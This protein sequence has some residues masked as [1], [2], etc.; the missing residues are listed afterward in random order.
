MSLQLAVGRLAKLV[1][2]IQKPP[3]SVDEL[4]VALLCGDDREEM[5]AAAIRSLPAACAEI[6]GSVYE[7]HEIDRNVEEVVGAMYRAHEV[8][9]G[10]QIVGTHGAML[11]AAATA[12]CAAVAERL[13]RERLGNP[14]GPVWW[15]CGDHV[16]SLLTSVAD[17]GLC[18]EIDACTD[19]LTPLAKW[20]LVTPKHYC[21]IKEWC[22]GVVSSIGLISV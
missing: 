13:L 8:G 21:E 5:R 19:P 18:V 2:V 20:T 4:P 9:N 12:V 14:D 17:Q 16:V 10:F 6:I 22:D 15:D 3:R 7:I 11:W 1:D